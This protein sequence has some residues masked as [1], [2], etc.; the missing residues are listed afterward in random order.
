MHTW[1]YFGLFAI[2]LC[3]SAI[4]TASPNDEDER[5]IRTMVEQAI[6]R[7]NKGDATAFDDFWDKDADY[8]SVDGRLIKGRSQIQVVFREMA[9]AGAG[10]QTVLIEQVR[11]ITPELA[12]VDGSWTVTGARSADGKDLPPINGR[13]FEVVQKKDGRW[14]FI[15]TREMVVFNGK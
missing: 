6:S 9:K 10:Q 7:L 14:R 3:L 5:T 2:S 4:C 11:F 12:T 13:G 8:V 1:S 15:V